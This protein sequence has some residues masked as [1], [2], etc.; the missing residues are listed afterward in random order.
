M[1]QQYITMNGVRIKQPLE[2]LAYNFETTY[3][4]DTTR[5]QSGELH[6][7]SMFTVEQLGYQARNVSLSEM[8]QILQIIAKGNPFTLHYFS[9]YYGQWRDDLFYV[10]QGSLSV[11]KL[12]EDGEFFKTLAFNMTGV[13]PI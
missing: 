11:G 13:N 8:S 12:T 3:T 4:E 9:P 2:N 7:T 10:G 6:S 1:S 5:V